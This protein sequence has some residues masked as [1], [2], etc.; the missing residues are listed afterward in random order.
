MGN[1][2]INPSIAVD[3]TSRI[4][5]SSI[6]ESGSITKSV[7]ASVTASEVVAEDAIIVNCVA[8]KIKTGKGAILYNIIDDSEEG[9]VAEDEEVIVSVTEEEGNMTILKSKLS[10]DGGKAWKIVLENNALSFED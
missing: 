8:K 6:T 1:S 7:L 4:F 9:I 5:S 10:I 3:E 2:E